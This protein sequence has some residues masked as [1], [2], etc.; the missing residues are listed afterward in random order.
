MI[1]KPMFAL[2]LARRLGLSFGAVLLLTACIAVLGA[3]GLARVNA[4][5]QSV[6][7]E[8]A[9][10]LQRLAKV[11]D[12][13]ARDRI[14]LTDAVLQRREDV[15]GQR[16]ADYRRNRASA[17]KAWND[18]MSTLVVDSTKT[19]AMAAARASQDLVEHGFDGVAADAEA[20]RFDLARQGLD[21]HVA[22]L[23]PVFAETM[24]KLVA[25]QVDLAEQQFN[26]A[27]TLGER[28]NVALAGLAGA[29]LALAITAAFW[30]TQNVVRSLGAEPD[31]LAAAA[32][33]IARGDLGADASAPARAGSVM[34][35]MQRMRESLVRVVD[36]VRSGV[37]NVAC[38]SAEIARGNQDLAGRTDAQANSL[39][40][41]ASAMEQLTSTVGANADAANRAYGLSQGASAV[42][43][44]GGKVV[45]EMVETMAQIRESSNKIA[46]IIGFLDGISFQT[47]MLALNAAVEAARA[48]EAG[49]SFAVVAGEVRMLAKR[50]AN[51]ASEIRVLVNDSKRCVGAGSTLAASAGTTMCEI[52]KQVHQVS[53]LIS[54]IT[55]ASH[56][57]NRGI[58]QVGEAMGQLDQTTQQNAALAQQS[59]SAA[60]GLMTQAALLSSAVSVFRLAAVE[61]A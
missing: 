50:S 47:N 43:T 3:W 23:H 33:R 56:E 31:A 55:T 7:A 15:A 1:Q 42:A 21:Q 59:T 14:L 27:Q 6:F 10:P 5:L 44:R 39:Q 34:A 4:S 20:G 17:E 52:V 2:T 35:S 57:Q 51:A 16:V 25:S 32:E 13:A 60:E 9:V 29:G 11:R 46:D 19:L 22:H 8:S 26:A 41:T 45:T 53:T 24:E 61:H 28:L 58:S 40:R 12:L 36:S 18:F 49:R 54:E 30:V 37:D 38:A 48:G